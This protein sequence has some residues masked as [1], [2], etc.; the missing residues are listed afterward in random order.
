MRRRL[1]IWRPSPGR[2]SVSGSAFVRGLLGGGGALSVLARHLGGAMQPGERFGVRT[3]PR[4]FAKAK[5]TFAVLRAANRSQCRAAGQAVTYDQ[6]CWV[7]NEFKNFW[8]RPIV[9][10]EWRTFRTSEVRAEETVPRA[11]APVTATGDDR[12][13][14][15]QVAAFASEMAQ[16]RVIVRTGQVKPLE[17]SLDV[18]GM[19]IRRRAG[20]GLPESF[21]REDVPANEPTSI[22]LSRR[23]RRVEE[24]PERMMQ[25]FAPARGAGIEQA[26]PLGKVAPFPAARAAVA[27][28]SQQVEIQQ[29]GIVPLRQIN[30][31]E[32]ADE[33]LKQLDR[34][35]VAARERMGRI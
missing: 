30:V 12:L 7:R 31:T 14:C 10:N 6:R 35:L 19:T 18:A 1:A 21:W 22:R 25:E 4:G 2:V 15:L 9:V 23:H 24:K 5:F 33:V 28:R 29:A 8:R 17:V 27:A 16:P 11:D 32:V 3:T 20:A 13:P 34:K 26:M